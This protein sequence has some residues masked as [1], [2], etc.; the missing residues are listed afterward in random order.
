MLLF[1]NKIHFQTCTNRNSVADFPA[2][3][4]IAGLNHFQL[5][6]EGSEGCKGVMG[7]GVTCA[8]SFEIFASTLIPCP[9]SIKHCVQI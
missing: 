3:G 8:V 9:G 1:L 4:E 7:P 6:G 2:L 5:K